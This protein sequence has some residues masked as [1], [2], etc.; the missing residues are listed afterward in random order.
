MQNP[1]PMAIHFLEDLRKMIDI[2]K[3]R[4][5]MRK[6]VQ[7]LGPIEEEPHEIYQSYMR[8]RSNAPLTVTSV[9]L[10]KSRQEESSPKSIKSVDSGHE[11]AT[12]N[13][14]SQ[15]SKKDERMFDTLI[16]YYSIY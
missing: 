6:H 1:P 5:N 16:K 3:Q 12:S 4:I 8:E 11:S 9:E 14:N 7:H 15:D 13:E 2:A 10:N